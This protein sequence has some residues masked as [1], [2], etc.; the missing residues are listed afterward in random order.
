MYPKNL[1]LK[2]HKLTAPTIQEL[3]DKSSVEDLF[4]YTLKHYETSFLPRSKFRRISCIMALSKTGLKKEELKD[5][6][7]VKI[8]LIELFLK[9]FGFSLLEYK[10][11]FR[12][13][14]ES[15]KKTIEKFYL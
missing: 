15:Y 11:Q 5:C 3:S 1:D 6:L 12:I 4:K 14:N 7:E 9:I 2:T 8:D 10:H 13:N